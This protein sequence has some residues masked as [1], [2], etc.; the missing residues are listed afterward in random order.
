MTN[1]APVG[2]PTAVEIE[3]RF[4]EWDTEHTA[5]ISQYEAEERREKRAL[6]EAKKTIDADIDQEKQALVS[7]RAVHPG[8]LGFFEKK[9]SE[10]L[11]QLR[12]DY[13]AKKVQRKQVHSR[14][15]LEHMEMFS[16]FLRLASTATAGPV[17]LLSIRCMHY[18]AHH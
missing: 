6:N 16:A 2:P 18:S 10:L 1:M 4:S 12:E 15:V 3:Q 5:I 11:N 9:R 13:E 8:V 17:S 7:S 14:R